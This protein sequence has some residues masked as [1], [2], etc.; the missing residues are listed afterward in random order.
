MLD[1][2]RGERLGRQRFPRGPNDVVRIPREWAKV[3]T[4]ARIRAVLPHVEHVLFG[5]IVYD[6]LGGS[7]CAIRSIRAGAYRGLGF[8]G[9]YRRNG[10]IQAIEKSANG[11]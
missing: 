10:K 11:Q 3:L 6:A 7:E 5:K 2:L 8:L 9:V 4:I 1:L